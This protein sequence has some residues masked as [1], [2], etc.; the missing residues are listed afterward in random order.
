MRVGGDEGE[1]SVRGA[2]AALE[3]C[4]RG[5]GGRGEEAGKS[6]SGVIAKPVT[7]LVKALAVA[8]VESV[9][10]LGRVGFVLGSAEGR[11]AGCDGFVGRRKGWRWRWGRHWAALNEVV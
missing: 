11:N 8:R 5:V 10:V 2:A 1:G 4:E 9:P 3:D 6:V 7:V